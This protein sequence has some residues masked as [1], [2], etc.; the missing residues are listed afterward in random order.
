MFN[1]PRAVRLRVIALFFIFL[2]SV[3]IVFWLKSA[4]RFRV[5]SLYQDYPS[6]GKLRVF[7][8]GDSGHGN[9]S[10][11]QVADAME[12]RCREAEPDALLFLGDNFYQKGVDS[13]DDPQWE[14]KMFGMYGGACLSQIPI[15]PVLGNHDYKGNANVQILKTEKTPRWKMPHRFYRV[16]F[17]EIVRVIAFDSNVPDMCFIDY[18]CTVDFLKSNLLLP[19]P[20][21]KIVMAHHPLTSGSAKGFNYRGGWLGKFML[22]QVCGEADL[23]LSGHSHHLEHRKL[24]GCETQFFVSGGG[25]APLYDIKEDDPDS[26]FIAKSFGFL[27]L[28]IGDRQLVY[29]FRNEKNE[30]LYKG[31]LNR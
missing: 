19:G 23:W 28:L 3:I 24:K 18:F 12:K 4:P 21:W 27:E 13:L 15:F 14:K 2:T 17:G 5:G 31:T 9:E 25:G 7:V 30:R 6:V 26:Q 16:D 11:R 20:K 22:P 8:I 29:Q 10:Q 1:I